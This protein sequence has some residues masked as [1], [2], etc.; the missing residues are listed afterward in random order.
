MSD[1]VR[2][3]NDRGFSDLT[4]SND[5][6]QSRV[7][8]WNQ[9]LKTDASDQSVI[10]AFGDATKTPAPPATEHRNGMYGEIGADPFAAN[11]G[12]ENQ[13][14]VSA[15]ESTF[16][17]PLFVGYGIVQPSFLGYGIDNVAQ[18]A[19][20]AAS[21]QT[22]IGSE[23]TWDFARQ[24][25]D[26][27]GLPQSEIRFES[28]NP[29]GPGRTYDVQFDRAA[30]RGP[31]A[32]ATESINPSQFGGDTTAARNG[33]V[34]AHEFAGNPITGDN[35]PNPAV[36]VGLNAATGATTGNFTWGVVNV[37]PTSVALDAVETAARLSY[38]V[39]A[40]G[41]GAVPI[42]VAADAN[43]IGPAIAANGGT[44]GRNA[45][46]ATAGSARGW[47]GGPA[48]RP[49]GVQLGPLAGAVIGGLAGALIGG[50]VGAAIGV[51]AGGLIGTIGGWL[52]RSRNSDTAARAE[53]SR[54]DTM[55]R[56]DAQ[57][58]NSESL[59]R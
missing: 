59:G 13:F 10:Q 35:G 15:P 5:L 48:G 1:L 17:R 52:V 57:W 33:L 36:A 8:A 6:P 27:L 37:V 9:A 46:V 53:K 51:V 19:G 31:R 18:Q 49:G 43:W 21:Q 40:V 16:A 2:A 4:A 22:L 56:N 25:V 32:Q 12:L 34:M 28:A 44:F 24:R 42:G 3:A 23:A 30:L 41:R 58:G 54:L 47:A 14:G 38:A 7:D 45:T 29:P 20:W 39:C 11:V 26:T 55:T 50:P